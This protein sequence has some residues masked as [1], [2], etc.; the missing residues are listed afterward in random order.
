MQAMK[1]AGKLLKKMR[2]IKTIGTLVL[3]G[4][5]ILLAASCGDYRPYD[6]GVALI[7]SKYSVDSMQRE[8]NKRVEG[9][10]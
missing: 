5:T 1:R 7:Q 2:T 6:A 10:Q 4:I 8:V 3:I 9:L